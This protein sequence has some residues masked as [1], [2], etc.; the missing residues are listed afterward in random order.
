MCGNFLGGK[1]IPKNSKLSSLTAVVPD[2]PGFR[3]ILPRSDYIIIPKG[4][5]QDEKNKPHV[6]L[7]VT[8]GQTALEGQTAATN[9]TSVSHSTMQNILSVDSS[10]IGISEQCIAIEGVSEDPTS[11]VQADTIEEVVASE[12]LSHYVRP[13]AHK[14]AGDIFL[15][16]EAFGSRRWISLPSNQRGY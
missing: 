4:G 11:F 7:H 6:E 8:H 15:D 5:L 12:I 16:E 3:K 10:Q 14:V 13:A 2:I 9:V 1:W